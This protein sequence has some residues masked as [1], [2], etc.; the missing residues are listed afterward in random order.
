MCFADIFHGLQVI[1]K[2]RF[3]KENKKQKFFFD[4]DLAISDFSCNKN[5]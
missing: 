2:P 5:P 1:K 4:A 3:F